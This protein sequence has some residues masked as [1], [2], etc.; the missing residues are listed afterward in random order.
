MLQSLINTMS[1]DSR[2]GTSSVGAS[3]QL[4]MVYKGLCIYKQSAGLHLRIVG[5]I[6][7]KENAQLLIKPAHIFFAV[8]WSAGPMAPDGWKYLQL[9]NTGSHVRDLIL[10]ILRTGHAC[11][12]DQR[13]PATPADVHSV[14]T[15][16]IGP[17]AQVGQVSSP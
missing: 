11:D 13:E 3:R 9:T 2:L 16:S 15:G 1:C 12:L 14:L 8:P 5:A 6:L 17:S 4:L 7:S 10:G